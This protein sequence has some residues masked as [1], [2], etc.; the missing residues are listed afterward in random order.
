MS[1]ERPAASRA[2]FFGVAALVSLATLGL[3]LF[4]G[5]WAFAYRRDSLHAG[6]LS[7]MLEER[8]TEARLSAG[9]ATEGIGLVASDASDATLER[10][11]GPQASAR[12]GE[13]RAKRDRFPAARLYATP[14]HVY[15]VFF[16]AEGKAAD[17][18]LLKR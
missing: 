17:A 5:A 16:D 6:R 7:R 18:A 12:A 3:A 1:E 9:L 15:V 8:P 13:V 11:L 14:D 2:V 4:L 10:L